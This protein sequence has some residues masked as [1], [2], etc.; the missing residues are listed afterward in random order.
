[1]HRMFLEPQEKKRN[2]KALL[3]KQAKKTCSC[4]P[5]KIKDCVLGFFPI[6]QWLP[7]YKLREYLLG[8]VMSGVIVG[9]LLVPQSIAYSLLAGL[10]PIYGLYTS[11]FSCIIYCIFG[12]S[13]HISV[14]IFGVVC[15]M[16]GQVV[17]REVE[18]AG[19]ELE[20][21]LPALGGDS[22]STGNGTLCD[23]GCYAMAVAAT[24]TFISGV[25]QVAMGFFQVGFVSVY[26]SD[27][28]L[29]GFVTGA[30]LTVLTSQVKYLLGLDIPRSGGIGS[31]ITTWINIFRNIHRT[32][33]CDLITSFLC[34]LV[35]I[36]AKE[37]NERFKSKL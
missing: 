10:E 29:S 27:S 15:L 11:F 31:L 2:M 14:S 25:Y 36:P 13:R 20:P 32:N 19:Y 3:I 8:D 37:L 1:H 6:L 35:L 7:K 23:K 24:I 4:T 26:L 34:F 5:A 33:I 18:R 9:V 12:T 16:L 17:D 30:S 22:N 21:A 28:L